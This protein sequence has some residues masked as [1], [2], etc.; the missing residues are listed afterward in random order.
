MPK[1]AHA[2]DEVFHSTPV[3]TKSEGEQ[4]FKLDFTATHGNV[5]AFILGIAAPL[6]LLRC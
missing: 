3:P 1:A 4:A 2:I 5:K 6:S